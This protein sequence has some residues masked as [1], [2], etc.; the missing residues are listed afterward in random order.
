MLNRAPIV[1]RSALLK[2]RAGRELGAAARWLLQLVAM[3]ALLAAVVV[4][5]GVA[6]A[7]VISAGGA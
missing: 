2:G 1:K 3:I 6:L 7:Y 5:L 4:L